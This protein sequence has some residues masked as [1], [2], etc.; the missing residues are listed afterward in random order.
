MSTRQ[1]GFLIGFLFVALIAVA[2]FWV[3]LFALVAG[4]VGYLVARALEGDLELSDL[5]ERFG[6][7]RR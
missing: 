2:S 5:T 3:A 7:G 4:V 6:A 1:F